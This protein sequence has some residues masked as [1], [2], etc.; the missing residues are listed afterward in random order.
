[1]AKASVKGFK[2][3]TEF[4]EFYDEKVV[5][6]QSDARFGSMI[7]DHIRGVDR[8][9]SRGETRDNLQD[10]GFPVPTSYDDAMNRR[11]FLNNTL[12]EN[13]YEELKP[14]LNA[15]EQM[16]NSILPKPMLMPNDRELGTFSLERAMMALEAELGLHDE[17]KDEWFPLSD[18]V[19]ILQKDGK[20]K[21]NKEGYALFYLK[22]TKRIL[23]LKEYEK[24]GEKKWGSRNKKVFVAI[25]RVPRPMRAIRFFVLVGAN[26]G[27]DTY[28]A[29]LT[30]IIAAQFLES[31]GYAIRITGVFGLYRYSG[32][33]F[34]KDGTFEEGYR[35]NFVDLKMYDE[36]LNSLSLLYMTAD[37]S[38]F[39]TR[40]FSYWYAEQHYREDTPDSG[41]GSMPSVRA[42]EIAI[43]EKIKEKE[44]EDEK[45]TLYYYF[46][47]VEVTSLQQAKDQLIEMVC[48]AENKN[49]EM[50]IKLGYQFEPPDT[51]QPKKAGDIDCPPPR[52]NP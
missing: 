19:A 51:S 46:G 40:I 33:N 34:K 47:G 32:I 48:D 21:V 38:F 36:T 39:R 50:L 4:I 26:W 5:Q 10:Y 42:M 16:S 35:F 18:G 12:Y 37:P 43:L 8:N 30:A 31:K 41:I 3:L 17:K 44:L 1:M 13:T 14:I 9:L 2:N 6:A 29:G 11:M 15:L 27:Y 24:N 7:S 25:D 20:A 22:N 52:Q 23:V 45:D 28:W 49:R